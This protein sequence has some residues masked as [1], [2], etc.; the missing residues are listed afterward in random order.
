LQVF[1]ESITG[2]RGGWGLAGL[3]GSG[4]VI[5]LLLQPAQLALLTFYRR[6]RLEALAC[7]LVIYYCF[8]VPAFILVFYSY[9]VV[10][11]T[12]GFI[13]VLGGILG[14]SVGLLQGAAAGVDLRTTLAY[15]TAINLST[16]LL[17][18]GLR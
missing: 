9:V 8:F 1:T 13:L 15:S 5:K 17:L 14:L 4:L 16:L 12:G 10:L 18:V 2:P 7:Y 3:T 11:V 6:L